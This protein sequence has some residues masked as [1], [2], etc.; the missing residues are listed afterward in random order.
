M[1]G[2]FGNDQVSSR[3]DDCAL[4]KCVFDTI[5]ELPAGDV[6]VYCHLVVQLNPLGILRERG[7]VV[8]FLKCHYG[9]RAVS[10][11]LRGNGNTKT[12]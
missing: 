6:D 7:V 11:Y 4:R 9:I 5:G 3:I 12:K 8:D 10:H 2:E 1:S